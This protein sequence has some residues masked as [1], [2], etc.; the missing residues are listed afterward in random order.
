MQQK[1][2]FSSEMR[3]IMKGVGM[4][5]ACECCGTVTNCR[6]MVELQQA[7]Q[8]PDIVNVCPA[9][10][11]AANTMLDNTRR[12]MDQLTKDMCSLAVR[13][14]LMGRKLEQA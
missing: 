12:R 10:D 2:L 3:Q 7:Y 13:T 1:P 9:C 11:K 8:C 6:D 4:N 5:V 14:L